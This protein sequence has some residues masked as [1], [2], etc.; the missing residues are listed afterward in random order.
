MYQIEMQDENLL[1]QKV[2]AENK[3]E[4]DM[5]GSE[6]KKGAV[7][8]IC[9]APVESKFKADELVMLR[10]ETYPGFYFEGELYT[11]I[12]ASDVLAKLTKGKK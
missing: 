11:V 7:F 8:R 9:H 6:D 3:T 10:P 4:F 2:E 1:V 5:G 12:D